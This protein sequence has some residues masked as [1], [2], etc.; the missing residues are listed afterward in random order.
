MK[1]RLIAVMS[2]VLEVPSEKIHETLKQEELPEWDSFHHLNLI[3]ALEEEFVVRFSDDE[4][5]KMTG[6]ESI[7]AALQKRVGE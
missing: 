2:A 4:V 5:V 7:F 3:M 6:F 1:E